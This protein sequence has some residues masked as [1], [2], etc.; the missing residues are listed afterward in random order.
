M[1]IALAV[2][3]MYGLGLSRY[4]VIPARAA[5]SVEENENVSA[6]RYNHTWIVRKSS[7]LLYMFLSD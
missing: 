4:A 7:L 1:G 2:N 5:A 6:I 3:F